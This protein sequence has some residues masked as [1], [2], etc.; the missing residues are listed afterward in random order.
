M[1][2]ISPEAI[3]L[4]PVVYDYLLEHA[5]RPVNP[6]ESL[7]QWVDGYVSRRYTAPVPH[8]LHRAWHVLLDIAYSSPSTLNGGP[9]SIIGAQPAFDIQMVAGVDV[10]PQYDPAAMYAALESMLVAAHTEPGLCAQS[11]FQFDLIGVATSAA[12]NAA[13]ILYGYIIGNYTVYQNTSNP[14]NIAMFNTSTSRF[15]QLLH[16]LDAL[17]STQELYLLGAWIQNATRAVGAE[18]SAAE[19]LPYCSNLEMRKH[20]GSVGM[21]AMNCE[22]LG[23]CFNNHSAT[24]HTCFTA[25][26]L[27]DTEIMVLN[28]K[29]QVR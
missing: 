20:C 13:F 24:P 16:E 26:P 1:S 11:S 29:S 4:N 14:A 8:D 23:C 21:P 19:G 25:N 7:D 28:A 22:L 10:A 6:T 18:A 15:R 9:P 5:W 2:G 27:S 3:Q 12:S 17:T